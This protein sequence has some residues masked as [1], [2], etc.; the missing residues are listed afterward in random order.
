MINTKSTP[1]GTKL[2][3]LKKS[4][5]CGMIYTEN[6]RDYELCPVKKNLNNMENAN[7]EEGVAK[8]ER[9]SADDFSSILQCPILFILLS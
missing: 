3:D 6:E 8:K 7:K 4:H 1:K 5:F 2:Q 9:C